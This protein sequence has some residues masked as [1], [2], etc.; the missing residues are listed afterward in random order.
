MQG[1]ANMDRYLKGAKNMLT[2]LDR[3]PWKD[4][5]GV[6]CIGLG[7]CQVNLQEV[8]QEFNGPL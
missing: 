4:L 6:P 7:S 3:L 2:K 1:I 5:R 8:A